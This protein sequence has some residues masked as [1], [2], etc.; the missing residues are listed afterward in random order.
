VVDK[1][2]GY[3]DRHGERLRPANLLREMARKG[4]RFYKTTDITGSSR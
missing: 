3:A 2:E 4:E 1:L